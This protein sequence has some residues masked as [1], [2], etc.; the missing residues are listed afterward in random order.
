MAATYNLKNTTDYEDF[1]NFVIVALEAENEKN[2]DNFPLDD[3][4]E[5]I[6]IDYLWEEFGHFLDG[7]Q[8]SLGY[9][10]F[11]EVIQYYNKGE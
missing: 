4:N 10:V 6:T 8:N 3:C 7:T 1:K 2:A 9:Q 5:P 11:S